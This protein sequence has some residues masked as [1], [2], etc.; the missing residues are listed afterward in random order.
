MG[1][2]SLPRPALSYQQGLGEVR[3]SVP[4]QS[5]QGA[6]EDD[7]QTQQQHGHRPLGNQLGIAGKEE[8]NPQELVLGK[9]AG[10]DELRS[11]QEGVVGPNLAPA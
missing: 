7:S 11:Q 3:Q 9:A 4:Q 10:C 5:S 8:E 1:P 6:E 2:L